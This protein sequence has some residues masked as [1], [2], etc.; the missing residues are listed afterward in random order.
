MLA[1]PGCTLAADPCEAILPQAH[2]LGF[3]AHCAVWQGRCWTCRCVTYLLIA[4]ADTA[5]AG[6]AAELQSACA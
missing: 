1:A 4:P 6:N 5:C 3:S 2:A